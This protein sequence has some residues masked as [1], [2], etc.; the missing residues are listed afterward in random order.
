MQSMLSSGRRDFFALIGDNKFSF[1]DKDKNYFNKC[2]DICIEHFSSNDLERSLNGSLINL[3][4]KKDQKIKLS[5]SGFGSLFIENTA[6]P[7]YLVTSALIMPYF[8]ENKRQVMF[9]HLF[10]LRKEGIPLEDKESNLEDVVDKE[11]AFFIPI[12]P[13]YIRNKKVSIDSVNN[14]QKWSLELEEI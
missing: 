13:V 6:K 4:E 5:L 7:F 11:D 8:S 3:D 10:D 12:V 2:W 1:K 9:D 14:Q